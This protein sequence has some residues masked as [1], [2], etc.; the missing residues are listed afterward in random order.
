MTVL[1]I[2]STI[3]IAGL[4]LLMQWLGLSQTVSLDSE[5]EARDLFLENF[6]KKSLE[7]VTL[8]QDSASALLALE[9]RC[10]GLIKSR[11]NKWQVRLINQDDIE[12]VRQSDHRLH[13][14]F[15]TFADPKVSLSLDSEEEASYWREKIEEIQRPLTQ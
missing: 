7:K 15:T 12:N 3:A 4:W 14:R 6:P 1:I 2:S 13:L 10:I 11:G 8:T 5:D 9:E